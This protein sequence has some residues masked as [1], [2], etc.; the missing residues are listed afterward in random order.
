[1]QPGM[2]DKFLDVLSD[3]AGKMGGEPVKN[4]LAAVLK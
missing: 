4:A 3:F 2:V 1:M